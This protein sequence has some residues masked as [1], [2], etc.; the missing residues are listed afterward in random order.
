M[1]TVESIVLFFGNSGKELIVR[2]AAG[3]YFKNSLVSSNVQLEKQFISKWFDLDE[4]IRDMM[5]TTILQTLGNEGMRP[6]IAAQML[7]SITNAEFYYL[8]HTNIIPLLTHTTNSKSVEV[9]V[10]SLEAIQFIYEDVEEDYFDEATNNKL[11]KLI[12]HYMKS[13]YDARVRLAAT[14]AMRSAVVFIDEYFENESQKDEIMA[15]LLDIVASNDEELTISGLNCYSEFVCFIYDLFEKYIN[16]EFILITAKAIKSKKEFLVLTAVEFWSTVNTLEVERIEKNELNKNSWLNVYFYSKRAAPFIIPCLFDLLCVLMPDDDDSWT[17]YKSAVGCLE[18]FFQLSENG[19]FGQVITLVM[20]NWAHFQPSRRAGAIMFLGLAIKN[21][22]KSEIEVIVE[23]TYDIVIRLCT[24]KSPQVRKGAF[25]ALSH[26]YSRHYHLSLDLKKTNKS[27]DL[28]VYG[29]NDVPISA[30]NAL[31][32]LSNI[33]KA[34]YK[35]IYET[36]YTRPYTFSMSSS[37]QRLFDIAYNTL[38]RPDVNKAKLRVAANILLN[39]LIEFHAQDTREIVIKNFEIILK[40]CRKICTQT[41]KSFVLTQYGE[42]CEIQNLYFNVLKELCGVFKN[43]ELGEMYQSLM[44][45]I[46]NMCMTTDDAFLKENLLSALATL[47]LNSPEDSLIAELPNLMNALLEFGKNSDS[48]VCRASVVAI[49]NL[50]YI[51]GS[52]I[53]TYIDEIIDLAEF[54]FNRPFFHTECNIPISRLLN[55][56]LR[57][58][59][60]RFKPYV[61]KTLQSLKNVI[62]F[63]KI[64]VKLS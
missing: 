16:R 43:N 50:Y 62:L 8:T 5:K 59:D 35:L 15:N 48:D 2:R 49:E 17:P 14:N 27:L 52:K 44:M 1:K 42:F 37:Y 13:G 51:V 38:N 41:T 46:I 36:I 25:F 58:L 55:R 21:C 22:G 32:A 56:F 60:L 19:V 40:V 12:I 4:N 63:K 11:L 47:I 26:I 34:S 64:E 53:E 39:S 10:A 57:I 45:T 61:K 31:L 30:Y 24:D 20:S 54:N 28:A 18:Y 33:V 6:N 29:A 3:L 7:V 23:Y 9:I